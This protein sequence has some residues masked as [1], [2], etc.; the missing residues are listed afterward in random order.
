[1][2]RKR[3]R[4]DCGECDFED[5]NQV[6]K[7]QKN[8]KVTTIAPLKVVQKRCKGRVCRQSNPQGRL[9]SADKFGRAHQCKDGLRSKCKECVSFYQKERRKKQKKVTPTVV[10]KLCKGGVCRQ[11]NPKGRYLPSAKFARTKN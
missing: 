1:M 5:D 8:A 3:D 9:L 10:S 7:K 6:A 2:I 11:A 4:T